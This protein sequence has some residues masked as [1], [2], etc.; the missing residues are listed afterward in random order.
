[1]IKRFS[2]NL[3]TERVDKQADPVLPA[4]R[5]VGGDAAAPNAI[6]GLRCKVGATERV[7]NPVETIRL[8]ECIRAALDR[9]DIL[10]TAERLSLIKKAMEPRAKVLERIP[11]SSRKNLIDALARDMAQGKN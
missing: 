8:E 6:E 10:L 4:G 2:R 9:P 7:E 5:K 3:L 1:M 11:A